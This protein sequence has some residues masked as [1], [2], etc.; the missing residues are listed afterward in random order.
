LQDLRVHF[1]NIKYLKAEIKAIEDMLK[2]LPKAQDLVKGSDE[3]Y[4]YCERRIRLEG[5]DEIKA[6]KLSK[7]Y[8]RRLEDLQDELSVCE[9]LLNKIEDVETRA[10]LRMYYILGMSQNEIAKEFKYDR[11]TVSKKIKKIFKDQLSHNS[12]S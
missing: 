8:K 5:S 4:P 2:N 7:K 12:H 6:S 3:E 9:D 10:L 11:S 1:E